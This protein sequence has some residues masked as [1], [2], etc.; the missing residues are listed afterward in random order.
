MSG[1]D[2]LPKKPPKRLKICDSDSSD[3]SIE[4]KSHRGKK[5]V[6]VRNILKIN[7]NNVFIF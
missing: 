3:S 6:H 1:S 7:K 2:R 4:F 5:T